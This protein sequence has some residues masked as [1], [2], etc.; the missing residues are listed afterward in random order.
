[1]QV[2]GPESKTY[3]LI[4]E[5]DAKIGKTKVMVFP[6]EITRDKLQADKVADLAHLAIA[7]QTSQTS[8]HVNSRGHKDAFS[9]RRGIQVAA[10][11]AFKE[12]GLKL[13]LVK[14]QW[15]AT[16]RRAKI[17]SMYHV[18]DA[19]LTISQHIR[20]SDGLAHAIQLAEN[21]AK[22]KSRDMYV[23]E[24]LYIGTKLSGEPKPIAKFFRS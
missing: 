15:V 3:N 8:P 6:P 2:L 23:H 1:M 22:A 4:V 7:V 5:H 16:P 9:R 14:G 18:H 11:R 20:K 17:L 21:L 19:A 24:E 10:G 13:D 12:L